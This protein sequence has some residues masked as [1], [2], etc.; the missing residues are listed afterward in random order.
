MKTYAA[1]IRGLGLMIGL[2]ALT[3]EVSPHARAAGTQLLVGNAADN[4]VVSY[5]GTTGVFLKIFVLSGSGGLDTPQNLT[6]GPDGN[7]YV[8]S[9]TSHSVKRYDGQTGAFIDDFVPSGS[10]G[11]A[12][13]DQVVSA[14]M[15]SCM[16][17]AGSTRRS[18]ATT[19]DR[20]LCRHLRC[21]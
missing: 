18:P 7:L 12:N 9:R 3:I 10:G 6:I 20:R 1:I 21:G 19:A 5:D 15:A 14:R 17:V 13:P 8:S 2:L 16:S 4:S 11:L